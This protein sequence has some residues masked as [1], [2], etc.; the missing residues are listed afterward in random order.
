LLIRESA[1]AARVAKAKTLQEANKELSTSFLPPPPAADQD[2]PS[3]IFTDLS[4]RNYA[5]IKA[6]FET[7]TSRIKYAELPDPSITE[8]RLKSM[9]P[10]GDA[11]K[12]AQE[13]Q[14]SPPDEDQTL[15]LAQMSFGLSVARQTF[16]I[17]LDAVA[18]EFRPNCSVIN[19]AELTFGYRPSIVFA[20]ISPL[21]PTPSRRKVIEAAIQTVEQQKKNFDSEVMKVANPKP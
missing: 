17:M 4:A 11:E 2:N 1:L 7:L 13:F 5:E 21:Y 6:E 16:G 14:Q 3:S 20:A 19:V 8:R 10:F 15:R 9:V 18:Y 12:V